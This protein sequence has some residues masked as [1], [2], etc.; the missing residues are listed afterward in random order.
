MSR[1]STLLALAA[2]LALG[3][4]LAFGF[5]RT[6]IVPEAPFRGLAVERRW[7]DGEAAHLYRVPLRAGDFVRVA[8]EQRSSDI[9]LEVLA[10]GE[11]AESVVDGL[12]Y[13]TGTDAFEWVAR[14]SGEARVRVVL[15]RA[16]G[17]TPGYRLA[18]SLP[19][20]AGPRDRLRAAAWTGFLAAETTRGA[21]CVAGHLGALRLAEQARAPDLAA[22]IHDRL[23][24]RLPREDPA[25]LRHLGTAVALAD[26]PQ[27]QG[28][29]FHKLGNLL[30]ELNRQPE[31]R[32]AFEAERRVA[33]R[34]GDR[35]REAY[36]L[37][38][39]AWVAR[40][41][42]DYEQ[43]LALKRQALRFWQELGDRVEQVNTAYGLASLSLDFG[44]PEQAVADLTA[45]LAL[46]VLDPG[47]KVDLLDIL[48]LAH[49]RL[50]HWD[51][52]RQVGKEAIA[53]ALRLH[54]RGREASCLLTLGAMELD[55]G[56]TRQAVAYLLP[57]EAI[58]QSEIPDRSSL[59]NVASMLGVAAAREGDFP[60]AF[61]RFR[62][63]LEG[64][65]GLGD[66]SARAWVFSH[67]SDALRRARRF[68]EAGAD[69][70]AAIA[71]LESLRPALEPQGRATLVADRHRFFER[72][73]DLRVEQRR[74]VA[75]FEASER[76][77]ARTLLDEVSGRRVTPPRSLAEIRAALPPG[78]VL[79][80]F[81]LGEA[82]SFVWVVRAEGLTMTILPGEG[83]IEA[84]SQP[85]TRALGVPPGT[86]RI[87][88]RERQIEQLARMLFG[89]IAKRL[90]GD[91]FVVVPD[92]ALFDVPF[93]ALPIPGSGGGASERLIDRGPVVT[94]P[95][96][97]LALEIR[98][99]VARRAKAPGG[100]LAVGDPVFG[101]PDDRLVCATPTAATSSLPERIAERV[102]S[103]LKPARQERQATGDDLPRIVRTGAEVAAIARLAQGFA[104]SSRVGFDANRSAILGA[105]LESFRILHFATH[106]WVDPVHPERSGLALARRDAAGAERVGDSFLRLGDLAG[107]NLNADLVSLSACDS[108]LG[109]Q[110]RGEGPQSLGRAFLAA[111]AANALVSLWRVDDSSTEQL[112]VGFYRQL[113]ERGLDP[114]AALREAQ[115][116]VRSRPGWSDPYYWGA[117]VLEGDWREDG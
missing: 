96:A 93:A 101:C 14:A 43:A 67:R 5:G 18:I 82:R 69:L 98:D 15:G 58:Y 75:A 10:P 103:A 74:P 46:D 22:L 42:G 87:A 97:S 19:R 59:A 28:A 6:A 88:K 1:G 79:L 55:L 94:L 76:S 54:D 90:V 53:G 91:R 116:A 77:R 41:Q 27:L 23:G 2:G 51:Q 84:A 81:W 60:L 95:S 37:S 86:V 40:C 21:A 110:K 50:G 13:A 61:E 8:V 56:R 115:L 66:E 7:R 20:P 45:G 112:M 85:A 83:V 44:D 36:A 11:V 107:L 38:G 33:R 29:A 63:A 102:R 80:D 25:A 105:P 117:F 89:P 4:G 24:R 34:A 73:V 17:A 68:E 64:Y 72:L 100:L 16:V 26:E 3:A 32:Q 57:A 30:S 39:L 49:R 31:A 104:V 12:T 106:G 70:E 78:Y 52:A 113:L 48:A 47:L 114:A 109:R 92:G 71:I 108:A 99:A 35:F 9:I 62:R 65:R 111:G